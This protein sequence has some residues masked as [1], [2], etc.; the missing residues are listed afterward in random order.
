[1]KIESKSR[2]KSV[3]EKEEF[4]AQVKRFTAKLAKREVILR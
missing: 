1:V 2:N 3:S 4:G